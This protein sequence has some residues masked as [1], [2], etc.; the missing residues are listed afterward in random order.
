VIG[1]GQSATFTVS[2]ASALLKP[3]LYSGSISLSGV[4]DG[5]VIAGSSQ[6]VKVT[7]D[8]EAAPAMQLSATSLSFSTT[9]G[10]NPAS[11][12]IQL[13]NVGGGTLKWSVGKSSQSWLSVSP[14]S[15]TTTA[16][17]SSTLT[18]AINAPGIA[19]SGTPY[20]ATVVIT[21]RRHRMVPQ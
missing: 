14:S 1:S 18:F 5:V 10:S 11:Q 15:G 9:A 16:G 17:S 12:T 2:V 7:L 13:S 20:Q 4:S 8:N 6:T 3:G 19:A 21:V